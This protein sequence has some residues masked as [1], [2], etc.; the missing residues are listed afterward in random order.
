MVNNAPHDNTLDIWCLGVLCY[1]FCTGAPPFESNNRKETF[2]KIKDVCI[3]FPDYL[4]MEVK[5]LILGLLN[6]IP[7]YRMS[8][9]QVLQ[10]SWILKYKDYKTE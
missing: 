3:T 9:D 5:N 8:L 10:H 2:R 4:S 7:Q 1:E 6:K